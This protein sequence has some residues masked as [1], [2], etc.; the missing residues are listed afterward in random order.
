MARREV[1][2]ILGVP[3][4][5]HTTGGVVDEGVPEDGELVPA[6]KKVWQ[7]QA[8]V[9]LWTCDWAVI[10]IGFDRADRVTNAV[11]RNSHPHWLNV[12]AY[13]HHW[14]RL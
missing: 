12:P 1:E 10:V 2:D 11:F 7:C 4:G 9:Q 3:G 5:N 13:L 14:L 6:S 8:Y